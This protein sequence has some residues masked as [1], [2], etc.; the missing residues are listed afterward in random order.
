MV[1]QLAAPHAPRT[2]SWLLPP[3]MPPADLSCRQGGQLGF[4]RR[5]DGSF[6][7]SPFGEGIG[8]VGQRIVLAYALRLATRE[9]LAERYCLS[10]RYVQS[11]VSGECLPYFTAPLRRWL[12]ESGLCP[13]GV[14]RGAHRERM[15]AIADLK[16][17]L[18]SRG[19]E[20][21]AYGLTARVGLDLLAARWWLEDGR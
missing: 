18:S 9:Q 7:V 10:V 12:T 13:D 20:T 21:M 17:D 1:A 15:R 2:L 3:D 16:R 14:Y 5:T 19:S 11:I 4:S 8:P 6:R